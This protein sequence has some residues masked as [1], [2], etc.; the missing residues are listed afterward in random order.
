MGNLSRTYS[1]PPLG[2]G[3]RRFPKT[4][5]GND[6]ASSCQSLQHSYTLASSSWNKAHAWVTK[7]TD[8]FGG[9]SWSVVT[10]YLG[11]TTLCDGHPRVPKWPATPIRTRTT[12]FNAGQGPT[13]TSIE[14]QTYG[15]DFPDPVPTCS[16]K[17]KD[18]DPLWAAYSTSLSSYL[19]MNATRTV[20]PGSEITPPPL[21]PPCMNRT[22]ASSWYELTKSMYGCGDC[23]IFGHDVRLLFFPVP[24]TVSRDMCAST[25]IAQMTYFSI[26]DDALDVYA[27]K[28]YGQRPAPPG[29]VLATVD[30]HTL[31]SGTAY[32]SIGKVYAQD[33]CSRDVGTTV[34]D[35]IIAM[36]SES[37]LSLRYAQGHFQYF[38]SSSTQTGYP[39]SYADFN[40]PIPWSA[41]NGMAWCRYPNWGGRCDVIYEE[42]Y[43]PQLAIPGAI[44]QLNS[45]WSTCQNWYGGLYDPPVTLQ[46]EQT[47]AVPT[48]SASVTSAHVLATTTAEPASTVQSQPASTGH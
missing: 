20:K 15:W 14:R 26:N 35:V 19:V 30:H 33:R 6:Y 48:F 34:K 21:T 13:S 5:S 44:R 10:D 28:S 8:Y 11:A 43:R 22:E 17:P 12:T 4:G 31:T 1:P 18:C 42:Q 29:A 41:W 2:T 39:M 38:G 32:I 47:F 16:I 40:H 36:H 27:G 46:T 24:T 37:I 45:R 7:Q 3:M 23:T 25:P 9:Q